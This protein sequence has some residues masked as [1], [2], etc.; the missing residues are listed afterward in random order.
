MLGD[1]QADCEKIERMKTRISEIEKEL[2]E[3]NSHEKN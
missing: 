3:I 1:K 2:Q